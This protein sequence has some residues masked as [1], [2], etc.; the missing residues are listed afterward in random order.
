MNSLEIIEEIIK[1][2]NQT[3]LFDDDFSECDSGFCGV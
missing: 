1:W 2:D 3:E